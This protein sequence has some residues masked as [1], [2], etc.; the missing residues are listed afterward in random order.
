MIWLLIILQ[1]IFVKIG[2][3]VYNAYYTQ[4]KY[5]HPA[6]FWNPLARLVLS[7]GPLIGIVGLVV[8]AFFITDHPWMFLIFTL[9]WWIYCG[10]KR[11]TESSKLLMPVLTEDGIEME[12]FTTEE[13]VKDIDL[14][15]R[16]NGHNKQNN[17]QEEN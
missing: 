16:G 3:W 7:Y 9:C 15:K 14:A 12:M 4:P 8:A 2:W 6:I 11:N 1:I 13:L 10:H 5:N 17:T